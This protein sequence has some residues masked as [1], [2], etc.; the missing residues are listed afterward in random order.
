MKAKNTKPDTISVL[1]PNDRWPIIRVV[2]EAE[3]R[4][5]V[6]SLRELDELHAQTHLDG[7]QAFEILYTRWESAKTSVLRARRSKPDRRFA[8]ISRRPDRTQV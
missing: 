4:R 7:E 2:A 3:L 5:L 6:D 8:P 1:S